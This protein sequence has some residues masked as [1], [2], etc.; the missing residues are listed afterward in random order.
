[1][2]RLIAWHR[3][4]VLDGPN[5]PWQW[6]VGVCLLPLGWL[7]GIVGY[8]RV[9]LYRSGF[10]SAYRAAVPVVSIGN[11]AVG[12]TGK[13]PMAD[14]LIR[15]F[16]DRGRKVAVVSRGYRGRVRDVAVVSAGE[17]PLLTAEVCGDEP[18]LL[19]RRNPG[20]V[21]LAAPRRSAGVRLAV[22]RFGA[23]IVIL[24]DGFQHLAVQR[25]LDIVLLDACRPLG[26]R[27]VLPAGLL[28]EFPSALDR[29]DLLVLT[30]SRGDENFPLRHGKQLF[31]CRHTPAGLATALNGE[32]VPLADLADKKG[33]AFAGIADPEGFFDSLRSAGLNLVNTLSLPDHAAYTGETLRQVE[34]LAREADFLVTTEK[35]GVKLTGD[36]FSLPCYQISLKLEFFEPDDIE[37]A[38]ESLIR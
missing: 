23:R 6:I 20:A 3:R 31:R 18:L 14:H 7:Y 34:K 13:T 38:L 25:D 1:M 28:R 2:E 24:D 33:I 10:F 32:C 15:Y 29:A 30:R 35:D 16:Q 9:W 27:R 8:V 36:V 37:R 21:V 19:A 22:E 26:N 5:D 12:G 11:I 17:G 4:M